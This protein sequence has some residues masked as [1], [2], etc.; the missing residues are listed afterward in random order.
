[1]NKPLRG[2]ARNTERGRYKP[3]RLM[4]NCST[5]HIDAPNLYRS[6]SESCVPKLT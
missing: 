1:M 6:L 3:T 5:S 4:A 2:D